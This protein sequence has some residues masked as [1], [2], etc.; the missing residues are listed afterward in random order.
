MKQTPNSD[1]FISK[2]DQKNKKKIMP[3]LPKPF[4][5]ING[6]EKL[7]NSFYDTRITLTSEPEY[8][9]NKRDPQIAISHRTKHKTFK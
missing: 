1:R 6:E 7:L 3:N 4:Q 2:F 9:S 5:R 8:H